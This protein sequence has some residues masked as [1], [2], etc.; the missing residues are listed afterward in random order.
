MGVNH[1]M[2]ERRSPKNHSLHRN[3]PIETPTE[4]NANTEVVS[5]SIMNQM[6]K[7]ETYDKVG[8]RICVDCSMFLASKQD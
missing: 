2:L 7:Q 1:R 5:A 3:S 4:V 6:T 8:M